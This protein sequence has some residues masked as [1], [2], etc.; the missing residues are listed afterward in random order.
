MYTSKMTQI[1]RAFFF[2]FFLLCFFLC[3]HILNLQCE[4]SHYGAFGVVLKKEKVCYL[5]FT[6]VVYFS[7]VTPSLKP[8]DP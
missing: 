3:I 6:S 1:K 4:D 2:S 5:I 7:V 8:F